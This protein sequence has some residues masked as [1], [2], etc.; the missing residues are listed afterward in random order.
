VLLLSR[1]GNSVVVGLVGG[2]PWMF[3]E[4]LDAVRV[5]MISFQ[6]LNSPFGDSFLF[7]PKKMSWLGFV[8]PFELA[9]EN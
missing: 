6:P 1:E 5:P 2:F 3:Q 4:F 8:N 9:N 7:F